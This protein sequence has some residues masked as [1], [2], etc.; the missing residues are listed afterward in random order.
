VARDLV[1]HFL[2]HAGNSMEPSEK[3]PL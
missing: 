1:D 2:C 3:N